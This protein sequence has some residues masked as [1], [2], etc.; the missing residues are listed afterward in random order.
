[1]GAQVS[2]QVERRKSISTEKK[3]LVDLKQTVGSDFPGCDYRPSDRKNWM[4]GLNP[5]N[6]RINQ[7]V[8]PGTHDSATNKIGI[9]LVTRPFAQCQ[10]LSIYDQLKTGARV[11][12]IRVQEDRRICHGILL[13]YSVDV[14]I[15]DV[16]RFLEETSSE[17]IILEIRTEFGHDDPPD[18]DKYLEDQLGEYLIHH[19][20]Q[21]FNRTISELL[22]KRVICVWKP[23][24]TPQ[25]KAGGPLWGPGHL[26]DNWIDTDLPSTKFESNIKHL[27][28][29]QPVANR[30]HFYRVENTVTP[31]ADNPVLC[32]KPVTD[33]IHPYARMFIAQCFA[34]GVADRL[35]IF[36]SDFIDEDFVDACVALTKARVE[37]KA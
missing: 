35:Q 26:K 2:A 34:R 23:R 17:I 7:I 1:M 32:V 37:G 19:D 5:D 3:S 31:Q 14:V 8:W 13:S 16:K 6:I 36:S 22:P 30:K 15:N 9:P 10:S 20:D 33:R 29:Q 11:L 12:D 28:E 18:F 24:K 4:S 21:V 25:P 27:G